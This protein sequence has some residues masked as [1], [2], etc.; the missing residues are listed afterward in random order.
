MRYERV[1]QQGLGSNAKRQFLQH[2]LFMHQGNLFVISSCQ[3]CMNFLFSSVPILHT[4][5]FIFFKKFN[6]WYCWKVCKKFGQNNT[7][8]L[9]RWDFR[10]LFV[11]QRVNKLCFWQIGAGLGRCF[12]TQNI[13]SQDHVKILLRTFT[14]LNFW[15]L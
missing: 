10:A 9:N 15:K 11:C 3:I 6:Y 4:Y 12:H 5:E 1:S 7:E 14:I 13:L 2:F 8:F